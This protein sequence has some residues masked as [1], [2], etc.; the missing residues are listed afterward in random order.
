MDDRLLNAL[1]AYQF[2]FRDELELQSGVQL[3]LEQEGFKALREYGLGEAGRVDFFISGIALEIKV[4]GSLAAVTRQLYRYAEH[5]CVLGIILLTS[6][7]KHNKLPD[8]MAG[9][10]VRVVVVRDLWTGV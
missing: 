5:A 7:R 2:Q 1:R 8:S 3:L 4:D 10:P 6:R 9:K